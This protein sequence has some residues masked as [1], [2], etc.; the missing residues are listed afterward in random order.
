MNSK[1]V[2]SSQLKNIEELRK[3]I[4]KRWDSLAS[5]RNVTGIIDYLS[6]MNT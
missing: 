4:K 6:C 1:N 3:E 2:E 5:S